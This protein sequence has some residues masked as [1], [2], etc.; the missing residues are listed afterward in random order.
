MITGHFL[1]KLINGPAHHTLHHLYFT[2][3][4]GQVSLVPL[5]FLWFWFH[6]LVLYMGWSCWRI[7]S[8]PRICS[9]SS[10]RSDGSE[11]V[12]G[13]MKK[14]F[15]AVSIRASYEPTLISNAVAVYASQ[16]SH[17]LWSITYMFSFKFFLWYR[18]FVDENGINK[19]YLQRIFFLLA[20]LGLWIDKKLCTHLDRRWFGL[21]ERSP[22][23]VHV[24]ES[25]GNASLLKDS[26]SRKRTLTE[27]SLISNP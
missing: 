15:D 6:T 26:E 20:V 27:L 19:T 12:K 4:Y 18:F 25:Q 2:V 7:I 23:I 17:I 3:N 9:G 10:D 11:V 1:E 14:T 24:F 21:F 5:A 13:W 22:N 16:I 8:S